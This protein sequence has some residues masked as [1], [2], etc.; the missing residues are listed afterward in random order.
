MNGDMEQGFSS[1]ARSEAQEQNPVQQT[2]SRN[3]E[4][5]TTDLVAIAVEIGNHKDM[6]FASS[7]LL[8]ISALITLKDQQS[9]EILAEVIHRH[10]AEQLK[11]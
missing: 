4:L 8:N 5:I 2:S 11:S 7:L 9:L 6:K 1:T 10:I 3:L